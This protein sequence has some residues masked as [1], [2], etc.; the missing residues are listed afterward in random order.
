MKLHK[1]K[2]KRTLIF[3]G[4]TAGAMA[5]LIV[6]NLILSHVGLFK[7]FYI[8][9]TPEELYTATD[10]LID[11]LEFVDELGKTD[12]DKKVKI[13]F[14][15]DPDHLTSS[16]ITR[17]TYFLALKLQN[18]FK[19][20]EVETVNVANNPM[21]LAQYKTTSL[22]E[23]NA[24]NIIVSYG[25]RYRIAGAMNF[26][27]TNYF[28]YDGEY[29]IANLI[30]SVTAINQPKAYF[31]TDCGAEYYD[32]ENP[33]SDM[34]LDYAY[35]YDILVQSGL[36]VKTLSLYAEGEDKIPEDCAMLIILNPKSD[37]LADESQ[38]N[39]IN[40]I[41]PLEK[42]DRFLMDNQ[43]A[44]IATRDYN[45]DLELYNYDDFLHE[46]GFE[47]G[48]SLVKDN[49]NSTLDQNGEKD[50][51]R[52]EIR[53]ETEE[54][55]Y[56]NAI[57]GDFA[58]LISAPATVV[59]NSGYIK[60]SFGNFVQKNESGSM[61]VTRNY[62]PFFT[63]YDTASAYK[64]SADTG[65]Y[66]DSTVLDTSGEIDLAALSI[67]QN[68]NTVSS[69][70]TYSYLFCSA[71]AGLFKSDVLGQSSYANYEVTAALVDNISRI[72]DYASHHL[73]S[74]SMNS[75]RFGGKQIQN[76][77]LSEED[78]MIY[79]QDG[80][81]KP[82][83]K[84]INRGLGTTGKVIFTSLVATVPLAVLAVGVIIVIKR[85]FL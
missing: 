78:E 39:N 66:I 51:T 7:A 55:S 36:D 81:G 31:V 15:T 75:H 83:L 5:V 22:T 76:A 43:G 50:P 27:T 60:C 3:T 52:V 47:F 79:K 45:K 17:Y 1:G 8:D 82:V 53:Y 29:K 80:S 19:N 84:K 10:M 9:L 33:T 63:T 67:R 24:S 61:I 57:Y 14:C 69:E 18:K 20:L 48:E 41:S 21:A 12:G 54:D 49:E 13:T 58:N 46:W 42:V 37:F 77:T 32:I 62:E 44:V 4:I 59:P 28:S 6:L 38:F 34:S 65:N 71:S 35:F 40:Y 16:V 73:G 64:F 85:K 25:D 56:A 70:Y 26:W 68:F 23:L 30:R 2:S 74:S 72:D 11:E